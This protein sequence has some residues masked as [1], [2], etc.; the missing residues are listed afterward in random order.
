MRLV[1]ITIF[2][3]KKW[4]LVS[5]SQAGLIHLVGYARFSVVKSL[6]LDFGDWRFW[7]QRSECWKGS[8][9]SPVLPSNLRRRDS[10]MQH[11]SNYFIHTHKKKV[12]WGIWFIIKVKSRGVQAQLDTG[13]DTRVISEMTTFLTFC[14]VFRLASPVVC[15]FKLLWQIALGGVA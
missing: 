6:P 8:H 12:G 5:G 4:L 1:K 7:M 11:I 2:P 13:A 9:G 10:A 15:L 14:I 3:G